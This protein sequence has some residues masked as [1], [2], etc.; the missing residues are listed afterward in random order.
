MS[1]DEAI[2]EATAGDFPV[3]EEKILKTIELVKSARAA[4]AAA[5][6]DAG[7]LRE[8]LEQSQEEIDRLR[9][10]LIGLRRDR[11]EARA[12][13]EKLIRQIDHLIQAE[14]EAKSI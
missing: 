11:E 1:A 3:L 4:Q 13:V 14:P 7:R 5:E 6:R 10:E 8:Q 9:A 2:T 12:R